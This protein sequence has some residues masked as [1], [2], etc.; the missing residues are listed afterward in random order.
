MVVVAKLEVPVA[1]SVPVTRLEV[2]AFPTIRLAIYPVRT[3]R[4]RTKRFVEVALVVEALRAMRV[5]LTVVLSVVRV[6]IVPVEAE[7]TPIVEE[8][9]VRSVIVVVARV[10]VPSTVRV[11]CEVRDEV[12]VIEPPVIEVL[13]SVAIKP[14]RALSVV[15][16][17]DEEVA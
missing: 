5:L 1:V 10:V 13:V 15:A 14:V 16:K 12:A 8:A 9:T 11:P 17:N 2:V 3:S 7:R 6:V 4:T